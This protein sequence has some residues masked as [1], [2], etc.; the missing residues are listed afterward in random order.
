[1]AVIILSPPTPLL[2]ALLDPH[3]HNIHRLCMGHVQNGE[4]RY[5]INYIVGAEDGLGV[6]NLH[7]SGLIA[8][9]AIAVRAN[10]ERRM[11]RCSRVL[12]DQG[13]ISRC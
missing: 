8:G 11:G 6:E 2:P 4:V 12:L 7:G 3:I 13:N 5:K 9:Y 1:M 10:G